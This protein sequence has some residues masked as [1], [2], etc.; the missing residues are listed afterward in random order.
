MSQTIQTFAIGEIVVRQLNGLFSLNDLHKAA[1]G[2]D[3]HRPSYFINNEQT[4]ALIDEI[5]I[6]GI[7]AITAKPKIGTYACREL[8]IAYAT[9]ISAAF[10]LKV[11]RVFL[12]ATAPHPHDPAIDYTRI[13]PAQAQGIKELV[14]QVVD[15]GVQ[16]FGE[17]WNRLH[18]KFRV[19]SYHELPATKYDEVCAYLR[20]KLPPAPAPKPAAMPRPS[21]MERSPRRSTLVNFD[22]RYKYIELRAED[23]E[24]GNAFVSNLLDEIQFGLMFNGCAAHVR[25]TVDRARE[26]GNALLEVAAV[27]AVVEQRIAA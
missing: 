22:A 19:N 4:K 14:H 9:W 3:K 24:P 8:V 26:I 20:G 11:I 25:L 12:D 17:T 15:A 5:Q 1:G 13:S 7:P 21:L 2:E 6:A 23:G 27:Q 10:H 16:G 18:H